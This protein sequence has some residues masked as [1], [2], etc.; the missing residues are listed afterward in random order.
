MLEVQCLSKTTN[1]SSVKMKKSHTIPSKQLDENIL[2][3]DC[4]KMSITFSP[5]QCLSNWVWWSAKSTRSY[6][7]ST[8]DR[9]SDRPGGPWNW[10]RRRRHPP[11]L[12]PPLATEERFFLRRRLRKTTYVRYVRMSCWRKGNRSRIVGKDSYSF[13]YPPR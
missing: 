4:F 11:T 5:S 8:R 13:L 7:A 9:L 12:P 1:C 3:A 2:V 6:R 10:P